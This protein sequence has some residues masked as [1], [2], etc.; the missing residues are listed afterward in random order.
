MNHTVRLTPAD[1]AEQSR[2]AGLCRSRQQV[3]SAATLILLART[4]LPPDLG[5]LVSSAVASIADLLD[6]VSGKLEA[7]S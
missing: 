2:L 7:G 6:A 4:T 3:E 1:R 5:P